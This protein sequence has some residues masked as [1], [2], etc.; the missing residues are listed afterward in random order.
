MNRVSINNTFKYAVIYVINV[1]AETHKGLLKIGETTLETDLPVD[2]LHPNSKELNKCAKERVDSYTRTSGIKYNLLYTE[3]A[4]KCVVNE[5]GNQECTSFRDH[6]VHKLLKSSQIENIKFCHSKGREWFKVDLETV[7]T[8][9]QNIK[10]NDYSMLIQE[11]SSDYGKIVFRPE[12]DEAIKK[13]VNHFKKSNRMLWNAKMRFGK[14]LSTLEL[15]KQLGY[16]KTII[17]THRPVVDDGWNKDFYKIFSKNENYEYASKNKGNSIKTLIANRTSFIYFASIQD[18]RGSDRVGGKFSKNDELFNIDWDLVVIDEAHEGTTTSLGEDVI[19]ELCKSKG[20]KEV[21]RLELSGTPFNIMTNYNEDSIY[22]WDYMME[23]HSKKKWDECN[24]GDS[25]PYKELPKLNIFT[26]DLGDIIKANQYKDVEDKAFNFKEFF[27][28]REGKF[29]HEKDIISFLNLITNGDD[30]SFYPYANE[31][32]RKL[33]RHTLWMVPGVKEAKALSELLEKHNVFGCGQFKVVNVAGEGDEEVANCSALEAV[34]NAIDEVDSG[35]SVLEYTIT[36][37]CGR[38]TTGVT[39]PEWTAVMMLSGS[40]STSAANYLQTIFRVQSPCKKYGMLKDSCYV[41]DFAPDRTLKMVAESVALSTKAGKTKESDK[42]IM[43]EFLNF[44]PVVS[45][46]GTGMKKY[47]VNSMLQQLKNAYA[48][49]AVISGFDDYNLYNDNLLK[50]DA[51]EIEKFKKLKGI[52]GS[53][54]SNKKTNEIDINNQGFTDEQYEEI[55]RIEKKPKKERTKEEEEALKKIEE[56]KK[57]RYNAIS[58]LRGISIRLP[59]LIYGV[60]FEYNEDITMEMLVNNI[61]DSSWEEFMPADVTKE[62]FREFIKYYDEDIFLAAGR[63]IRTMAKSADELPPKERVVKISRLFSYFKNPDKETVL[64]PWRVVNMHMSDCLGGY[65]FWDEKFKTE[66]EEPRY[67]DNGEVTKETLSNISSKVLEMNSKT[68]LYPLFITYSIYKSRCNKYVGEL[69]NQVRYKLWRDTVENNLYV[70]C[71]TEMAKLITKRT[72]L[73]YKEG[74]I[75]AHHFQ[76]LINMLKNEKNKFKNKIHSSKCWTAGRSGNVKFD[77][78]V[79]NPPYQENISNNQKNASLSK[80]LF[81]LFI[82][83]SIEL[84]AKYVSLITPSRWFTA[85]AQDKSFLKLREFI[86]QN[87]HFVSIFNYA[88]NKIVFNSVDIKGG[89]NYFLFD[90]SHEGTV[91][92]Y[93]CNEKEKKLYSRKLFEEG[94]DIIISVNEA[95]P[96]LQKVKENSSFR[97]FIEITNGRNAFGIVGKESVVKEITRSEE[98]KDSIELRCAKDEILYTERK[99]VTKNIDIMQSWKVF[100]SKSSDGET[101]NSDK[102][103]SIIGKP[104]IGKPNSACTDSLIPIGKFKVEQEAVNLQKYMRTKFLRFMVGILKVSQNVYQN[105]YQFVPL[106]NFTNKSDINWNMSIMEIDEQLFNKYSFTDEEK[107]YIRGKIK[108]M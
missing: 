40:Y 11:E 100:I 12:Q 13:T 63:K 10:K 24:F 74:R 68:G 55:E 42:R 46:G 82:E 66:L 39:V 43:G 27:R 49:K 37:S 61:D 14:T 73:G 88:N 104:Y 65:C 52:I 94:L 89:V 7:K 58:I 103:V 79:G 64:T 98:F 81:P 28:T 108:D 21:R 96:I 78:I 62:V 87:N 41:F 53:T 25:N 26:Y 70:I 57:Q 67:V 75:N 48:E 97:S 51:V 106:Q 56:K 35:K 69:T 99:Y 107:N 22:T 47:N 4:R 29:I 92:F 102:E 30:S 9:I 84:N 34:K 6:D 17:I 8:A 15:I 33:F 18:L 45:V 76:N 105:V 20:E 44:C 59:L 80:Q 3:L 38:L 36:I 31:N 19:N 101:I 85:D 83:R 93:E 50:L 77:V 1:E 32:F 23:Q 5:N 54:K 16:K 60:N 72:L 71:K 90:K 2:H 86:K 91:K 95:I